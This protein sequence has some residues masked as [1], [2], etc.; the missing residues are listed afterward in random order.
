[1]LFIQL[2]EYGCLKVLLEMDI[3]IIRKKMMWIFVMG[4]ATFTN[5][6]KFSIYPLFIKV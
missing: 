2:N 3:K 1:M 6:I 4:I 5:N